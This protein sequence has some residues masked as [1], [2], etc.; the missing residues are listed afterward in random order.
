MEEVNHEIVA[1]IRNKLQTSTLILERLADGKMIPDG[2]VNLA[3]GDLAQLE[4]LLCRLEGKAEADES[5]LGQPIFTYT[6]DQAAED[7]ILVDLTIV[8]TAWAKGLFNFVTVNLLSRGYLDPEEKINVPNILDLLNQAKE[9]VRKGT[10]D[11]TVQDCFF[12]GALEL[13]NGQKQEIFI[14]QNETG[15]FTLMLPEDY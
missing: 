15:K 1:E 13:P 5:P 9:I 8:N 12:S 2:F 7:G 4:K 11:F 10:K 3:K 6:C 14:Q